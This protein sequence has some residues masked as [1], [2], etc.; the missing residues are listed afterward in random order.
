MLNDEAIERMK[1]F[2][3]RNSLF[4]IRYCLSVHGKLNI[5]E[6]PTAEEL[7]KRLLYFYLRPAS[8][9]ACFSIPI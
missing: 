3:I 9:R 6:L 8:A 4:D 7:V 5:L 2:I 1:N